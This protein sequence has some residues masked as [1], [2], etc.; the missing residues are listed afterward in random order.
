MADEPPPL[1]ADSVSSAVDEPV[2]LDEDD[3]FGA[4]PRAAPPPIDADATA[5]ASDAAT[6][7][8]TSGDLSAGS[9]VD[10]VPEAEPDKGGE[11]EAEDEDEL[12]LEDDSEPA[13]EPTDNS[14]TPEPVPEPV[15]P[16]PAE[17]V[18]EPA[19]DAAAGAAAAASPSSSRPSVDG[20]RGAAADAV[21]SPSPTRSAGG[22]R[23]KPLFSVDVRVG[24]PE[25]VGVGFKSF[26]VY[27]VRTKV[28]VNT[29]HPQFREVRV[30][31]TVSPAALDPSNVLAA[32][33]ESSL[34]HFSA[35]QMLSTHRFSDFFNM[36]AHLVAAYPG[37]LV[38]PCPPKDA[39]GTGVVKFKSAGVEIMQFVA[40]RAAALHRFMRRV[41]AHPI[42]RKDETLR[43]FLETDASVPKCKGG[44]LGRSF[45]SGYV[46]QSE[47]FADK[48]VE[49]DTLEAQLKKLTD[50]VASVAT[51]RKMMAEAT[52]TF[53][54]VFA[55]L[56][57][58]EEVAPLTQAMDA[59][60]D[61]LSEIQRAQQKVAS[62]DFYEFAEVVKDY[63][64]LIAAVRYCFQQRISAH[65]QWMNAKSTLG[66]KE[67][68]L[69]KLQA[70]GDL[71][72]P[73]K[74][75]AAKQQV[76][77]MVQ[78]EAT[79]AKQFRV[80]SARVKREV[81]RFDAIKIREFQKVAMDF[82]QRAMVAQQ[83]VMR[84]WEKYLPI[85]KAIAL[86]EPGSE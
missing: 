45:L 32:Q 55:S 11:D 38:P 44:G 41:V 7:A 39:M 42:L 70:K 10:V 36:R 60:S 50:A 51:Q 52:A 84:E 63:I 25:R 30:C 17:D 9:N 33:A 79:T 69:A 76:E 74:V 73:V 72:P 43:A 58:A 15:A 62:R 65:K 64:P 80:I 48:A 46:E 54:E 12:G 3:P 16:S 56:A 68:T 35:P 19:G 71:V 14:G 8:A 49:L 13:A 59:F 1:P 37:V 81:E 21:A 26:V 29:A 6:T 5:G 78:R 2:L 47:W 22:H 61:T 82:V 53:S 57:A 4:A 34:P 24:D 31:S 23:M 27:K 18:S 66:K 75:D 67:D 40:R 77:Q 86:P 20:A 28:D 85:A 83:L